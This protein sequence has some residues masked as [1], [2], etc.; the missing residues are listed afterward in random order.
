MFTLTADMVVALVTI[1]MKIKNEIV[2]AHAS[3][4]NGEILTDDEVIDKLHTDVAGVRSTIDEWRRAH[5]NA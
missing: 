3:A 1:G 5:P 2:A 4:H